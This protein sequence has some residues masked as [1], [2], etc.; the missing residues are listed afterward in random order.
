MLLAF[1]TTTPAVTVALHDGEQVV[2]SKTTVDAM[3]HGEL[4][5]PAITA[6]LDEAWVPRADLA[7]SRRRRAGAVHRLRVGLITAR[8]LALALRM[9]V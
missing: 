3:H 1:D 4:L 7:G 9:P 2:A 5:A 8:T 6:L